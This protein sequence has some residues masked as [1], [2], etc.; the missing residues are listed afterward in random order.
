[1]MT[2]YISHL[3]QYSGSRH[4]YTEQEGVHSATCEEEYKGHEERA[5]C[6]V[7]HWYI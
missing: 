3:L 5:I 4:F 6:E 2:I 1:M 7:L